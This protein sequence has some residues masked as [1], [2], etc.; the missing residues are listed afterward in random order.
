LTET[1]T[2]EREISSGM[3]AIYKEYMGR[4]PETVSTTITGDAVLTVLRGGLTK[5]ERSLVESGDAETVRNVRR[6]FQDAMED[7]IRELVGRSLGREC[8]GFLSDHDVLDDVAV[9]VVLLN[10]A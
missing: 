9:E 1:L 4:G 10:P 8:N 3:V 2:P 7:D 5:A 6:K